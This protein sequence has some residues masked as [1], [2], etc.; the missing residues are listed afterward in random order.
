MVL[1]LRGDREDFDK[2]LQYLTKSGVETEP[3]SQNVIRND[4]QCTH[5]GACVAICSAG[6]FEVEPI[7][8][9]IRF[10]DEKC[11]ACGLCIRVCPLRAMEVRF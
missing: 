2:G 5:C 1:E 9:L 3:L 7:T 11:I 6:A 8:R 10:D 4:A